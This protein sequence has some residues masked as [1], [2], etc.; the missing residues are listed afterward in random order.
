MKF[1]EKIEIETKKQGFFSRIKKRILPYALLSAGF[2][3]GLLGCSGGS[4]IFSGASPSTYKGTVAP[5]IDKKEEKK[6]PEKPREVEKKPS[7]EES[8][9][10]GL[11]EPKKVEK[12]IPKPKKTEFIDEFVFSAGQFPKRNIYLKEIKRCFLFYK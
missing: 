9:N 5:I 7:F 8:R 3:S 2:L 11:Q 1:E 4:D 12:P 6:E 10:K